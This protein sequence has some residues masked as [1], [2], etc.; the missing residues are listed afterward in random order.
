MPFVV[1]EGLGNTILFRGPPENAMF[2]YLGVKLF[3]YGVGYN[4]L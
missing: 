1:Y 3:L 2:L 4:F